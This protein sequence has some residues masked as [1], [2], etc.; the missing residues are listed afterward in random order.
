MAVGNDASLGFWR[1]DHALPLSWT[2]GDIWMGVA[3]VTAPRVEY[4]YVL[5]TQNGCVWWQ[6]G[7]NHVVSL[8][9]KE[10]QLKHSLWDVAGEILSTGNPL[11]LEKETAQSL[12]ELRNVLEAATALN[13]RIV[14]PT[15]LELIQADRLVAEANNH[16]R[17]I[18]KRLQ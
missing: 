8:D 1:I 12:E 2:D 17:N 11:S 6:P 5:I 14:D 15:S 13:Q 3:E 4:K 7:S 9:Q 16:T 10:V 18:L